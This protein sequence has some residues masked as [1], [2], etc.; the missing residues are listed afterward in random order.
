MVTSDDEKTVD[1]VVQGDEEEITRMTKELSLQA[2]CCRARACAL[3][4][5]VPGCTSCCAWH[6][7]SAAARACPR[8]VQ[9]CGRALACCWGCGLA[10]L[11]FSIELPRCGVST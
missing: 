8:C 9:S 7:S 11:V 2:R 5:C 3:R 4:P 10:H 6:K 1:V